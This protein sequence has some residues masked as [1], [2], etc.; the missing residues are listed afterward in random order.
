MDKNKKNFAVGRLQIKAVNEEKRTIRGMATTPETDRVGDV[1]DPLGVEFKNPAPLLWMHQH[2]LPVGSVKFG[3]PTKEGVPFEATLPIIEAPSQLKARIDEAW[4]SVKAGL[5]RAVSIGFRALEW[6]FNEETDGFNFLR[7]EIYELSLVTVPANPGATIQEIKSFDANLRKAAIGKNA[8]D[9]QKKTPPPS[10]DSEKK[11]TTIVKF[12]P[13]EGENMKIKEQ[14]KAYQAERAAKVEE[15]KKLLQ[16]SE[17]S[18]ETL[19]EADSEACDTLEKEIETI[20]KHLKRLS[21]LQK[22]EDNTEVKSAGATPVGSGES[23]K[24]ATEARTS[25]PAQIRLKPN[26]EKGIAFA[27]LA[28][29]MGL[30]KGNL[31]QAAKIAETRFADDPRIAS[32]L[33]K[34]AVAA[35]TTSDST[36]AG[37]LVGDESSVFADFAEYLRPMTILGKFGMGNLPSLRRVPFRTR[38]VGQTSGGNG[39]WVGEGAPKPLTKFDFTDTTLAPLK[40]AAISVATMELLRD[41]SPSADSILRDQLA[42]AVT[43]RLDIDFIDPDKSASAGVSPASITNGVTPIASAGNTADDVREDISALL[44]TYIEANNTPT[45]GVL[46]M[47]SITA[48]RLSL[49]Q[50]PLGQAE[51]P[52]INMS[53]GM[54]FGFPVIVS[55]YVQPDSSGHYVVMVNASD[56]YLGDEGDVMVDFSSE[57]SLQMAD[58]PTNNSATPTATTMVSMFQTNSVAFR[59]ERTI[60][61]SKRRASA[62]ALLTGVNWGV[63]AS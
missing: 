48:L 3:T 43:E 52:G 45:N 26:H 11:T 29:S 13:K 5:V 27:R 10:G 46:V 8:H 1:I 17:E 19:D 15:M 7:T 38:L 37:P 35:G 16:K 44:G 63:D 47:S 50:N 61:W 49:M 51:F 36:W 56:I 2:D 53:G 32:I 42:A 55:Q 9:E 14:I 24:T 34:G 18:G 33:N 28:K 58:D 60:N 62:V 39:Y 22:L 20:D 41:S 59:A 30:A 21:T 54:L 57:A 23:E 4:E 31:M 6:A 25:V 12:T 40:V